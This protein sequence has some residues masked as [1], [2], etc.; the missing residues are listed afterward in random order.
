[1]GSRYLDRLSSIERQELIEKLH[2]IQ[3]GKCYICNE[4]I[5]LVLHGNNIDIDHIEPLKFGG[6]DCVDNFALTHD[7]CNRSK[8]VSHFGSCKN[9]G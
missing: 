1:M 5:D 6:R 4:D 2:N 9:Y 7:H 8:Q 3:H